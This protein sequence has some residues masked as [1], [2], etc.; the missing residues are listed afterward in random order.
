MPIAE[1]MKR[2]LREHTQI[3]L[4]R[5]SSGILKGMITP[6][7]I[8]KEMIGVFRMNRSVANTLR[9]KRKRQGCGRW[10][11]ASSTQRTHELR[12]DR[13]QHAAGSEIL[14]VLRLKWRHKIIRLDRQDAAVAC[15]K[16]LF[17]GI[18]EQQSLDTT[19]AYGSNHNEIRCLMF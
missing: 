10:N 13:R 12:T 11:F 9:A 15:I 7:D 5:D 18:S 19:T 3:A 14:R 17:G 6:V 16:Y 4:V 8:V 2:L 1:A